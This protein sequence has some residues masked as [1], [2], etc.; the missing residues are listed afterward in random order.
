MLFPGRAL[1]CSPLS[2]LPGRPRPFSRVLTTPAKSRFRPKIMFRNV[3]WRMYK[4]TKVCSAHKPMLCNNSTGSPD[5]FYHEPRFESRGEP[6][7]FSILFCFCFRFTS[8]R[9]RASVCIRYSFTFF[10]FLFPFFLLY[11]PFQRKKNVIYTCYT[12]YCLFFVELLVVL[13]LLLL[14]LKLHVHNT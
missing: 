5:C 12:R 7:F 3:K 14:S 2:T 10:S 8:L 9:V 4:N 11:L 6:P 1:P 13:P